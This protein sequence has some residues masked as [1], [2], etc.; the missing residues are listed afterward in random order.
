MTI[1]VA[2]DTPGYTANFKVEYRPD[3]AAVQILEAVHDRL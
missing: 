1:S 3:F 2:C